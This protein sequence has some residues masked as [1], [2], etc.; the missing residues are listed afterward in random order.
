[1]NFTKKL[2]KNTKDDHERVDKHPFVQLIKND[3]NSAKLY[4]E[5][6][7]ICIQKIQKTFLEMFNNKQMNDFL[8]LFNK[9]K[10][11][12][13]INDINI[14]VSNN[15]KVLL[16]RCESYPLEHAYMFYLGLMMGYKILKKYVQDD[17]LSYENSKIKDLITEFKSFLDEAVCDQSQFI[18]TVSESYNCIKLVFDDYY[19]I[20]Q[21]TIVLNH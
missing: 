7:K 4:I 1:M 19:T 17:I 5:F 16:D 12:I 15:L 9:L 20:Y 14:S 11:D 6:N 3:P 2:Y 18:N 13:D 10:R 8:P 21:N